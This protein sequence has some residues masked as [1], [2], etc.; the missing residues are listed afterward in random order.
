M[1]LVNP[2]NQ[3]EFYAAT[4]A[5]STRRP[6]IRE[7]QAADYLDHIAEHVEPRRTSSSPS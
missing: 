2:K 3:V 6:G 4:S 7:V 1:G 5:S